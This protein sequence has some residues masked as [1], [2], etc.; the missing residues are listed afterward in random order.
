M[1]DELIDGNRVTA[2]RLG[3]L[4]ILGSLEYLAGH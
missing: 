3:H 4:R 2:R 1:P